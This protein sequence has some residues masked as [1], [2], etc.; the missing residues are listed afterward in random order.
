M[1]SSIVNIWQAS[2]TENGMIIQLIENIDI[3]DRVIFKRFIYLLNSLMHYF[4]IKEEN[5]W[6]NVFFVEPPRS[7]GNLGED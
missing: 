3:Y 2:S 1:F 4:W 5:F 7:G 6:E